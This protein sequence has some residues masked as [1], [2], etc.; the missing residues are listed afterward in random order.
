MEFASS[1]SKYLNLNEISK[2]LDVS[3]RRVYDI[4]NVLEGIDLLEK[5]GKNVIRWK[6][7]IFVGNCKT[8]KIDRQKPMK[9]KKHLMN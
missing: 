9:V 4:T 8:N 3:K 1:S 6:Y 5:T 7:E 2:Q